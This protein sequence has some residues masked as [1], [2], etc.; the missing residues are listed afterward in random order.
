MKT[1]H[2]SLLFSALIF[3]LIITASAMILNVQ[4]PSNTKPKNS[5]LGQSVEQWGNPYQ[6]NKD[7][8]LSP[9]FFVKSDDQALD[10]LPLKSTNVIVNIA[11]VIADVTVCQEY[12][13]E[14][15]RPIEAIYVFP[16]STRAA[17]Y[18][19]KMTLGE[20]IIYAKICEKE[21]AKKDYNEAKAKGKS[22]SLLEQ[23]RPNVF[24]MNVA[25]I[26]PG[27][28]VKVEMKYTEILIPEKG[29][30][31]FI[32]P[33]VVGPR[34]SNKQ[35][36]QIASTEHWVS[37]PFLHQG[38]APTYSF[39]IQCSI[40]AGMPVSD[41]QCPSHH[42]SISF[43]NAE[44]A[45]IELEP[46]E[47]MAGNR[48]FIL[49]YRLTGEKIETGLLLYPGEKENFFLA[50]IQPP[51]SVKLSDIPARDYV[52]IMDVSGSMNG[53]P[54]NISKMLMRN[55]ISNLRAKDRF[56]VILFAGGDQLFSEESVPVTD[57]NLNKALS[58]I[59]KETGSGGTELLPA[60]KR[61]LGLK[62][63]DGYSRSFIITTDG[64]VDVESD[65]FD[66][67]RNHRNQANFFPFGIG[68]SVNRY[69]IEG[70]AR[71]GGGTPFIVTNLSKATAEATRFRD[72]IKQPVISHINFST[73]GFDTYDVEPGSLQDVF[74]DRPVIVFGKYRG[75]ARGSIHLTG[76]TARGKFDQSVEVSK[77]IPLASNS[78]L[79][80]LWAREQIR[81]LD[82]FD[83]FGDE[84]KEKVLELGLKYN[85]LTRYTSFL[86]IDNDIR[87]PSG[88]QITVNQPLPL[89]DG[90]TDM[91]VGGTVQFVAPIISTVDNDEV[92]Y[93]ESDDLEL[94]DHL[95]AKEECNKKAAQPVFA[96][97]EQQPEFPGGEEKM[98]KFIADNIRYPQQA[99]ES[100]IEGT[101]FISFVV[102]ANGSISDIKILR[103][104]GGGC[105]EEAIRV[106]KMMP[107][108]IPGKQDGKPV[109]VLFNLPVKFSLEAE[110]K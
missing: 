65:A 11:G 61:A 20:R 5:T 99:A 62:G 24:Q 90:V 8:T 50:M 74:S 51:R 34:Y 82:D 15:K 22:A 53:D 13:N 46:S 1:S 41:V 42:T 54:I 71:A 92:V 108:W 39:N 77:Y 80:Y 12:V 95:S 3:L 17:V 103:G 87:N 91:A 85:L 67:I 59:D 68:T 88:K 60:L 69:L 79:K 57:E 36:S 100:A 47:N 96:V 35:E 66:L 7:K 21:K 72:Y 49:E 4:H 14:G 44:K 98:K 106:I 56:N 40:S 9:Y 93:E 19:M 55:L 58:F 78:A 94:A 25:N 32:Y 63:T 33:T 16:A 38:A 2:V 26:M 110:K 23:E 107:K 43:E 18:S 89:P 105:D 81:N 64:Y 48:D 27:D 37:N 86:A 10:Q 70:M 83:S 75:T 6:D 104:I 76:V 45:R 31:Q 109:P 97:D 30:Y 73:P 29:I 28:Q 52:F 102:N 84:N 101:V